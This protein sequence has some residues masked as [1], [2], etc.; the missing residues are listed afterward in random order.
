MPYIRAYALKGGNQ[1]AH[2]ECALCT[3]TKLQEC[4]SESRKPVASEKMAAWW[5][6][7]PGFGDYRSM[8]TNTITTQELDDRTDSYH[9]LG[10]DS[11]DRHHYADPLL[12]AVWVTLNDEIAHVEPTKE[13]EQWVTYTSEHVGWAQCNY[14]TQSLAEWLATTL[15]EAQ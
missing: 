10:T 4:V 9:H 1:T 6:T 14:S 8:S 12:G 7:Q 15:Q 11:K 3:N 13:I 5:S 2:S